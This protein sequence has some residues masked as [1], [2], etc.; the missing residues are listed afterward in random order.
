MSFIV[1]GL[2]AGRNTIVFDEKLDDQLLSQS[3]IEG[4]W[5]ELVVAGPITINYVSNLMVL[6][7]KKDFSFKPPTSDYVYEYIKY[8][9]SFRATLAQVANE[10]Y[11]VFLGAHS[12]M[13]RIQLSVQQIPSHIKTALKLLTSASPRLIQSLLPL[14]LG[15]IQRIANQCVESANST[16]TNYQSLKA[17]LQEITENTISTYGSN[18][19]ELDKINGLI[20]SSIGEQELLNSQ[21][22][23]IRQQFDAAREAL[24]KA[25]QEYHDAFHAIPGR[26]RRFLGSVFSGIGNIIGGAA[27]FIGG[28]MG[29]IGCIFSSCGGGASIHTSGNMAFQNAK[30]KAQLALDKLKEAEAKYD[31]WYSQMLEKQNKLTAMILYMSQLDISSINHQTI[32]DILVSAATQ[33]SAIQT[34]WDK[35]TRFFTKLAVQA[36]LTQQTILF[37]FIAVIEATELASGVLDDAD[38]EFYVLLLLDTADEI[39]RGAHL[40][41]IMA[42][43]YYDISNQYMMNQIAGI[44]KLLVIQTDNE[45]ESYLKQLAQDTLSTSAKVSRM[46]LERKRQ[47]EQRNQDRQYEYQQFIKQ[48]TLEDLVSTIGK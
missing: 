18:T 9:N 28:A 3:E 38:R 21:L 14:T 20:N 45:R 12:H 24:R 25:Q 11:A 19:A 48:I 30:E 22:E 35:M 31:G 33:I 16:K 32:I 26:R 43:T 34:Q 7:S 13:D 29:S 47:Y 46:A 8:P 44:S 41:Y 37:E 23:D 27:N 10:M 40:L 42:K 39:D 4:S 36:E 1:L 6:A 15:N 17:L 2:I 5:E